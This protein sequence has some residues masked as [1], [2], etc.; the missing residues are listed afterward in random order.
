MCRMICFNYSIDYCIISAILFM[1]IKHGSSFFTFEDI[2]A[3]SVG[4]LVHVHLL[5][6]PSANL[7]HFDFPFDG[8]ISNLSCAARASSSRVRRPLQH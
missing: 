2:C 6:F 1:S 3:L 8:P 7:G 4:Y 5:L